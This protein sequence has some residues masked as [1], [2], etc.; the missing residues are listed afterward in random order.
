MKTRL[1]VYTGTGNSLWIARQL[2]LGLKEAIID[3]LVKSL[4]RPFSVIPAQAGIQYFHVVRIL[5]I[6]VFTGMTTFYDSIIIEFMPNLS[7]DFMVEANQVGIIFPVHIWG[8]PN[9]V[10]QFI[11]QL[12]VKPG[13]YLFALAVNAGQVAAKLL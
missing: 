11:K 1:Y 6:P 3:G 12:Q 9:H 13:T 5:W 8:L 4:K 7:R 2:A 10:I